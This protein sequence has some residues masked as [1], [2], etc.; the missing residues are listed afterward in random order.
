MALDGS[1]A[2]HGLELVLLT[3][4]AVWGGGG[5]VGG[6]A[7]GG[8]EELVHRR[9][10]ALHGVHENE[11]VFGGDGALSE[12]RFAYRACRPHRFGRVGLVADVASVVCR[13]D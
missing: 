9:S 13:C 8:L 11:L 7:E 1:E 3:G 2:V 10:T 12:V 6:A 4:A 5:G